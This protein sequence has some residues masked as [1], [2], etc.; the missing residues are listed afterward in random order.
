MHGFIDIGQESNEIGQDLKKNFDLKIVM[1]FKKIYIREMKNLT[2][3]ASCQY[4]KLYA[5][6]L[7]Y[8]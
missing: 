3:L 6:G 5:F 1:S 2:I 8:R 7:K 4:R